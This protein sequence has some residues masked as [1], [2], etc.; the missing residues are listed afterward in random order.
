MKKNFVAVLCAA[1]IST[2]LLSGCTSEKKTEP[3]V[4]KEQSEQHTGESKKAE[5]EDGTYDADFKQTVECFM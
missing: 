4:K 5:L 1:C 3:E 2:M